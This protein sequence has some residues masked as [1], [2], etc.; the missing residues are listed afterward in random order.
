MWP[1]DYCYW[2]AYTRPTTLSSEHFD[3]YAPL[4]ITAPQLSPRIRAQSGLFTI[5]GRD[6]NPHD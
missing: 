1:A 4:C 3:D 2:E 5:H 6:V